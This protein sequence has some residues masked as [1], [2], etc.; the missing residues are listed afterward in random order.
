MGN[1][2]K[3]RKITT[4]QNVEK[5]TSTWFTNDLHLYGDQGELS[6][7]LIMLCINGVTDAKIDFTV[8]GGT[9]WIKFNDGNDLKS[10][11]YYTFDLCI[12]PD[13]TINFKADKTVDVVYM[14]IG[15][16]QNA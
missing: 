11:F 16:L 13:H 15:E 12:D 1:R 14:T 10:Y 7:V 4:L 3:I 2:M 5:G 8:D 6:R 9:N